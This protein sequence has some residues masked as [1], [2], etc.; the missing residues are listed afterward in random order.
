M[1]IDQVLI[2]ELSNV[3]EVGIYAASVRLT[4]VW[5][6]IAIV[7]TNSL[8]PALLNAK[9]KSEELFSIRFKNLL[10]LLQAR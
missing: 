8:F 10:I 6:I 1:K 2:K 3:Y 4:E 9:E 5:Y 7:I